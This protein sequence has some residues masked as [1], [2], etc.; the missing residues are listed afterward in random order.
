MVIRAKIPHYLV[1][2]E[3]FILVNDLQHIGIQKQQCDIFM[4]FY[5]LL[6]FYDSIASLLFCDFFV[7]L[8]YICFGRR[9]VK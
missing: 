4:Y 1:F 8:C 5:V 3:V 7:A 9:P 6:I 2:K